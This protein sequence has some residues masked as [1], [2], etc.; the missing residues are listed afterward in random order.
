MSFS[1][2]PKF[3]DYHALKQ[4]FGERHAHTTGDSVEEA[5]LA[6]VTE[7][8]A[9]AVADIE[10]DALSFASSKTWTLCLYKIIIRKIP[11]KCRI[12]F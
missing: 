7:D 8:Q 5:S 3:V 1:K 10:Q 4:Q 2:F 11:L 6:T 9:K 12:V